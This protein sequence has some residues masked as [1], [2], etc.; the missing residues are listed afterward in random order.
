MGACVSLSCPVKFTMIDRIGK[1]FVD[2]TLGHPR[3]ALNDFD[4]VFAAL[5]KDCPDGLHVLGSPLLISNQKQI[6]RFAL[7]RR[8]PSMYQSSEA[9]DAGGLMS[10]SADLAD[11]YKR[12][13]IT[14]TES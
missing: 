4:R 10:Y 12:L 13:P 8:L 5:N 7:K 6:A 1:N 2:C 9:V 11:S 14:W 3:A